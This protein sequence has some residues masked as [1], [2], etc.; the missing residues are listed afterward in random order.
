MS[1][2]MSSPTTSSPTASPNSGSS[3]PLTSKSTNYA[4][5]AGAVIGSLILGL[6]FSGSLF[7][8]QKRRK[9]REVIVEPER[10]TGERYVKLEHR[11]D[12]LL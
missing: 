3:E 12:H 5:I 7:Y 9:G 1:T 2:S 10:G 4:W 8:R 11:N 6:I